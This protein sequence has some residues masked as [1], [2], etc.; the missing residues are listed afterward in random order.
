MKKIALFIGVLSFST[1]SIGLTQKEM[2]RF[3]TDEL[4]INNLL[5]KERQID[6]EKMLSIAEEHRNIEFLT[7]AEHMQD[8]QIKTQEGQL[9]R[10]EA[11]ID[12]EINKPKK[13]RKKHGDK[14]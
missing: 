4:K 6:I 11:L 7:L 13:T 12:H 8:V 10:Y 14:K 5:A 9:E 1:L 2:L 3:L